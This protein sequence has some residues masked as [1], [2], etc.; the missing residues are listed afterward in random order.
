MYLELKGRTAIIT[1]AGRRAGLG[2]A[3]ALRLAQEG[4]N[5]VLADIGEAHSPRV[6]PAEMQQLVAELQAVGVQ[7]LPVICNMLEPADVQGMVDA[8]LARE[9]L[10]FRLAVAGGDP[11]IGQVHR[12]AESA[13]IRS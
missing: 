12:R 10:H 8:A 7:A 11:G 5:I 9:R 1:G 2:A 3:M 13:V 4:V 6:V